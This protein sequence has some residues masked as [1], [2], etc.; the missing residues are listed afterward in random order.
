LLVEHASARVMV[1]CGTD[2]RSRVHA[3]QPTFI[4]LT[5]GHPDHAWGLA[6]GAPCPVYATQQTLELITDYPIREPRLMPLRTLT[7][8]GGI[9]FEAFPVDHSTRAPAVGYRVTVAQHCFFYVPDVVAI[10]D[11]HAAL[12]GAEFYIGDGEAGGLRKI[13]P[14]RFNP[15]AEAWLPILH[16][17]RGN[18]HF[19]ALYSN[20]ARAHELGKTNDWVVLYFHADHGGEAQRTVVTETRGT[21][22]GRQVVRGREA[23]CLEFYRQVSVT[24]SVRPVLVGSLSKSRPN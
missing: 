4:V 16:T 14:K 2:W 17:R 7:Q 8:I 15:E 19:A 13:A 9:A 20:T 1:D 6:D 21:L 24:S 5:H 12:H 3:I 18:W 22:A 23:E 10:H 11:R